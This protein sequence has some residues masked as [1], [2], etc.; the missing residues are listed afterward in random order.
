MSKYHNIADRI[1]ILNQLKTAPKDTTL[2]AFCAK[3]GISRRTLSRWV[4]SDTTPFNIR[5]RSWRKGIN[6]LSRA[7]LNVGDYLP[8]G[9]R[10]HLTAQHGLRSVS[11]LSHQRWTCDRCKWRACPVRGDDDADCLILDQR[12]EELHTE[13]EAHPYV[14]PTSALAQEWVFANLS[15]TL[16]QVG[17]RAFSAFTAD[18]KGI[19]T[20]QALTKYEVKLRDQVIRLSESLGLSVDAK[21]RIAATQAGVADIASRAAILRKEN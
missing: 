2:D 8:S 14:D 9:E 19:T 1:R 15:L 4:N 11:W 20:L 5:K 12:R 7:N 10:G 3:I 6:P 16:C 21:R 13:L 17:Y 18:E